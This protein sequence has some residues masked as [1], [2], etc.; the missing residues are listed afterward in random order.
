MADTKQTGLIRDSKG[1]II[2]GTP[3][4]GFNVHPENRSDGGWKKENTISYQ[5]NRYMNMDEGEFAGAAK[6][7]N[8]TMAMVI[9]YN[10]VKEA[11][12]SLNDAK[13]ITDRTVGKAPQY[14]G[15]GD[16]AEARKALVEFIHGTNPS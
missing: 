16:P 2:G 13:E 1:R 9:A 7:P 6:E 11:K 4:A 10:R 15:V 12:T 8:R 3:P 5:Y 14:I